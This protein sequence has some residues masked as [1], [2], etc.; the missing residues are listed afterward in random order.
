MN[1]EIDG[2][3][4]KYT[5]SDSN[6][7]KDVVVIL[8]GWGTTLE[9]YE[10]VEACISEKY[11]VIRLDFPG[12][13][14]SDEP[15]TPWS[16][17]GYAE[18]FVKF[19]ETIKIRK[20]TLI[21]HSFGGRVIIKLAVAK[22]LPFEI[23]NIVLIDSAGV[24]PERT[25]AQ[26]RKIARY[27]LLKKVFNMSLVYNLFPEII[28]DWRSKQGSEDYKNA[29]P[30]M[31]Q[32]LVMS[33]NEDLTPIFP[34]V[35]QEVLLIW[36]DLDTATPLKDAKKMEELMPNAGLAVIQGSGHYSFLENPVLFKRIMQ[37]YFK[38]GD[39]NA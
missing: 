23:S 18:F 33:V 21:G 5:D 26:K 13:G 16:V 32:T 6:S 17:D 12:F 8:Q 24:L 28:D 2:L 22:D 7:N 30:V 20:A 36:G 11:R 39:S 35:K 1:I 37:S 27:K 29:S 25:P 31:R 34:E 19:M 3:T 14:G 15:S 9:V 38:I 10:S 4:I